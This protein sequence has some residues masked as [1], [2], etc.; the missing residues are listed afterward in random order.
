M[1]NQIKV[2]IKK[3]SED[4]VIPSYSKIGDAGLDLTATSVKLD[5]YG[6]YEY[7]TSLAIVIPEGYV[8]LIFPRSSI[9][10]VMQT[11]TN[12]VAVIDSNFRGEIKLKFKPTMK[13]PIDIGYKGKSMYEV[14]ERIGQLI[15]MPFPKVEFEEVNELPD[16]ERG[17]K[18][19]GSSGN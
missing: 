16:S 12:S 2:Q 10:K 3:L 18:G 13:L 8:G 15:V 9:C 14:G 6:N 1:T 4:A 7:G 19:F 11:L 5:E 17:D